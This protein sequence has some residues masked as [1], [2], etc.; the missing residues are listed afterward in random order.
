MENTLVAPMR[1]ITMHS[2]ARILARIEKFTP[3]NKSV[4]QPRYR[5]GDLPVESACALIRLRNR[6]NPVVAVF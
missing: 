5:S 3:A 2:D 6:L 4:S 1:K